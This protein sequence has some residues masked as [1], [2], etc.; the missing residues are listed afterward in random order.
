MPPDI[1]MHQKVK[2]FSHRGAAARTARMTNGT[3][4][5]ASKEKPVSVRTS[6]Y[7]VKGP[8]SVEMKERV[9]S[10]C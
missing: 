2:V 7:I 10:S 5:T 8:I 3:R 4:E 6:E 9:K 1:K